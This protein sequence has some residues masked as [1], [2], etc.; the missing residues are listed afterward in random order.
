MAS[1]CTTKKDANTQVLPAEITAI[2]APK[3]AVSDTDV[4]IKVDFWGPDGCSSAYNLK[5]E[6]VGQTI[7]LT[8]YYKH[9]VE[10]ACTMALVPL[11]L[12]YSFFADLPGPYFFISATNNSIADTLV[13]Y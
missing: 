13:V 2:T 7:T 1:A 12:E 10:T 5:A 3:T 6:K 11:S 4:K 8:A 9:T